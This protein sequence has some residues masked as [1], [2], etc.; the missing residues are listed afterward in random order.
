MAWPCSPPLLWSGFSASS[1][2]PKNAIAAKR[3][4]AAKRAVVVF[5]RNDVVPH[6]VLSSKRQYPLKRSIATPKRLLQQ[7]LPQADS[8]ATENSLSI[9]YLVGG[10]EGSDNGDHNVAGEELQRPEL[11]KQFR[12]LPSWQS[13]LEIK[14]PCSV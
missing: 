12:P 6:V 7:D 11:A 1:R 13:S 2:G 4:H 10:C 14:R 8:R 3:P 9:R 5:L